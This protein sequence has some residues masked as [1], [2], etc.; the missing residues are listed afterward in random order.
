MSLVRAPTRQRLLRF[1]PPPRLISLPARWRPRLS[2]GRHVRCACAAVLVLAGTLAACGSDSSGGV[3]A[4]TRP[5]AVTIRTSTTSLVP[6]PGDTTIP[7]QTST[8]TTQPLATHDLP[9]LL[10]TA[11]G[12]VR[13]VDGVEATLL[14]SDPAVSM[15]VPD[16][17]GS[18]V[19]G[20]DQQGWAWWRWDAAAGRSLLE[21]DPDWVPTAI[22]RFSGEGDP[23]LLVDGAD[24]FV[25]LAQV[26]ELDGEPTLI[27]RAWRGGSDNCVLDTEE[28]LWMSAT[29]HL[30]RRD[31]TTG[32]A[33]GL[34]IVES[35]ESNATGVRFSEGGLLVRTSEYGADNGCGALFPM[36][37]LDDTDSETWLGEGS[38]F[39]RR[40]DFG[41][42]VECEPNES[43]GDSWCWGSY[44]A[45]FD[46]A[47]TSYAM[48]RRPWS[49]NEAEAPVLVLLDAPALTERARKVI[50][51][52][53]VVTTWVEHDGQW[54]VVGR[55]GL[56]PVAV[57]P[58]GIVHELPELRAANA[59]DTHP[60]TLRT[61][62]T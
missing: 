55:E 7:S 29:E 9:P 39:W 10:V 51:E 45:D 47:G 4:T 15:A 35:F 1:S 2:I 6:Y 52:P 56:Q 44:A 12:E 23:E 30:F 22:Y 43:F 19:Y 27:Y 57:G 46:D 18:V 34:G 54:T 14:L 53:G 58:D 8:T 59:G 62:E 5:E 50:G 20:T 40:C 3:G 13:L 21:G 11:D 24:G 16:L 60:L 42:E 61:Q 33:I 28:C 41:P 36:E 26:V 38:P 25:Q 48:A 49:G 17:R 32:E 31:F 37:I